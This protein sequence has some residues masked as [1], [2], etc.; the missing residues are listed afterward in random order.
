MKW[1]SGE[2]MNWKQETGGLQCWELE[3]KIQVGSGSGFTLCLVPGAPRFPAAIRA[4][5]C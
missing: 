5:C 4:A 1:V 2:A 3:C